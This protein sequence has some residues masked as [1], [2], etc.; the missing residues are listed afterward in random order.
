MCDR[1]LFTVV[2]KRLYF[3]LLTFAALS[4]SGNFPD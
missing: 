4:I 3:I 2:V 1:S